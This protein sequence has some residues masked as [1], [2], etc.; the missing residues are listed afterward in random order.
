M[1]IKALG[2]LVIGLV[3]LGAM[4]L[5]TI[6]ESQTAILL[7]FGKIQR[8]DI[9]PGLHFKIP[10]VQTVR[11]F[12]R[13][14]QT[15][16]REPERYLTQ[17]QKNVMVDFFVKWKIADV[18]RFY[19]AVGGDI[20]RTNDRLSEQ[21]IR[22][23]R[24]EFGKRTVQQ[25]VSGERTEIMDKLV[26]A[27]QEPAV[28]LGIEIIDVRIKRVDLPE[29]VSQSVYN[30]M[31]SE[32]QETA[33]RFRSEGEEEARELRAKAD[34]QRE[35][36]IAEAEREAQITRGEGD[37]R[38]IEIYAA[39]Y[40]RD[41]EFYRFYRSLDAYRNTFRSTADILLL[42]P[43]SEFFRYFKEPNP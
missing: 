16:D 34:K 10:V 19:T 7:Q 26:V 14:I 5:F 13:R 15:L 28:E 3:I 32:R 29:D 23:S 12:D 30:R 11:T 8:T 20:N 42:E 41:R 40:E 43:N 31:R 4:S 9:Q 2:V 6:N 37:A 21:I 18:Q 17:E 25:V 39:A 38:A 35:V 22:R 1:N 33:N 24:D 27:V 36:I